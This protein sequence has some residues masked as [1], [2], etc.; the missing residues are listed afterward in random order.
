MDKLAI[1]LLASPHLRRLGLH[2]AARLPVLLSSVILFV[3]FALSPAQQAAV[4]RLSNLFIAHFG[5][6][7]FFFFFFCLFADDSN[8]IVYRHR[9]P[10]CLL[11]LF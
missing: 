10:D 2:V 9:V 7:F 5:I 1:A 8:C 4:G 3:L 11:L 6:F